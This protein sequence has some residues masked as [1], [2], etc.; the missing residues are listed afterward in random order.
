MWYS[1]EG[2]REIQEDHV[3]TVIDFTRQ[4]VHREDW[5]SFAG[6]FL[7]ESVLRICDDVVDVEMTCNF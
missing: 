7:V 3:T 5:L 6:G 1:V 2:F 4:V